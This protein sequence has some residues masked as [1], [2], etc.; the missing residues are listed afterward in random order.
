MGKMV[1][2]IVRGPEPFFDGELHEPGSIV[3]VDEDLVSEDDF[4]EK[5]VE[6]TLNPP[7]LDNGKLVRKVMETVEVRTRFRPLGAGV[8]VDEG[9]SNAIGGTDVFNVTEFLKGGAD[10]IA[11]TIAS[12]TVDNHLGA[13]E[14]GELAR[15]GPARA[16]VKDAVA[17]RLAAL[18]R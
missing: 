3:V 5:E 11:A 15:K 14:Q 18:S 17:D 16:K 13:I 10:D 12:G 8:I 7:I 6:V 1:Q 2:A 9:P 4:I